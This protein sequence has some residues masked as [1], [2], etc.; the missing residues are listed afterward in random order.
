MTAADTGQCLGDTAGNQPHRDAEP[1]PTAGL[2][3]P[4]PGAMVLACRCGTVLDLAEMMHR[5]RCGNA[6]GTPRSGFRIEP[7]RCRRCVLAM[8]EQRNS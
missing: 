6:P 1:A 4:L 7:I 2:V 3:P 5:V 8:A